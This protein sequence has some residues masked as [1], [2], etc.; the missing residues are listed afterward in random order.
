MKDPNP[1]PDRIVRF[2]EA[3]VIVGVPRGTLNRWI[4]DGVFPRPFRLTPAGS[5]LGWMLS[6]LTAWIESRREA[7]VSANSKM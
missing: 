3:E 5:A 2:A 4:A 1:K 7:S 6:D